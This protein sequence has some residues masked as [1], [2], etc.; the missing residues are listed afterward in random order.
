MTGIRRHSLTPNDIPI[1]GYIYEVKSGML[2]DVLTPPSPRSQRWLSFARRA[3]VM[4]AA[5]CTAAGTERR[6]PGRLGQAQEQGE[7]AA[8]IA[9]AMFSQ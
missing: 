2:G 6:F 3:C 8:M 4:G 7:I 9:A 5:E 1:Y